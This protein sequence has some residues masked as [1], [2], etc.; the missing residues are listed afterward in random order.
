MLNTLLEKQKVL[1]Y[2]K[3]GKTYTPIEHKFNQR[4]KLRNKSRTVEKKKK[5][6]TGGIGINLTLK[7]DEISEDLS[8]LSTIR[9][10]KIY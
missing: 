6:S 10:A 8:I 3:I 2:E 4:N 7:L 9:T 5:K 1:E